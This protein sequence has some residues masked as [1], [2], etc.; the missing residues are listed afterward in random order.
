MD[1]YIGNC[2]NQVHDFNYRTSKEPGRAALKQLIPIGGQIKIPLNLDQK[3]IDYI[4]E[5]HSRYGLVDASTIDRAKPFIGLVYSV[6]KKISASQIMRGLNHNTEQL[7]LRGQRQQEAAAI[8]VNSTIEKN[9]NDTTGLPVKTHA[10]E[11]EVEPDRS[12]PRREGSYGADV[13]KTTT[14]VTR[15][16]SRAK[17]NVVNKPKRG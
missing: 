9:L 4:L 1:L 8:A 5:Q 6:D 11:V 13:G 10:M 16:E 3:T 15:D 7:V 17:G 2:T 14:V 12:S